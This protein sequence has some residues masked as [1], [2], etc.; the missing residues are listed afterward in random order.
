MELSKI[1]LAHLFEQLGLASD[2]KSIEAFAAEHSPLSREV[3]LWDAAFWT[4]QQQQLLQEE[5]RKDADWAYSID[6]LNSLLHQR[7]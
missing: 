3:L 4:P 2:D 5:L 1:T 7:G 6:E